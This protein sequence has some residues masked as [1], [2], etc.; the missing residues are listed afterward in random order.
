M[1]DFDK[2]SVY[3]ED[4]VFKIWYKRNK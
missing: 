1:I 3:L 2:N 4:P